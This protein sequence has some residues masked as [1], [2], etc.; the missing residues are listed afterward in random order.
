M[1]V[2]K[3]ILLILTSYILCGHVHSEVKQVQLLKNPFLNPGFES[4]N[5]VNKRINVEAAPVI[6]EN[7]LRATL[8]A[9]QDSIANIDG[10]MFTVGDMVKGYELISIDEGSA[11]LIKNNKEITL[12]VSEK[13]KNLK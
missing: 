2:R 10:L 7:S 4:S 13:H 8:S 6:S 3:I 5:T 1:S 9:S 12:H 11:T